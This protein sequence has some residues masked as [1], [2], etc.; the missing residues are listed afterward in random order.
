MDLES[1]VKQD[2]TDMAQLI[3]SKEVSAE[4][5][6]TCGFKQLEKVNPK[7]NAVVH[8]RK[9]KALLEVKK[10]AYHDGPFSGIPM[11]L[12]DISQ[13]LKGERITSGSRLLKDAV[14]PNRSEEHTSEL[15]SRFDLVCRL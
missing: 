2:A 10:K 14:A 11:L 8:D 1:Y 12:K 15:Q 5:L 4:E 7:L 9:D 6:L 13:S 3:R